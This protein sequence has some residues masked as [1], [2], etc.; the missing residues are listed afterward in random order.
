[1][2]PQYN[3][4][5]LFITS[6]GTGIGK[7]FLTSALTAYWRDSGSPVH[8]LKPVISGFSERDETSDT[9]QLLK[10]LGEPVTA[11]TI[12]AISPW[13]YREPLGP[14]MAA[15]AEGKTLPFD[16]L[17]S[18][19]QGALA[20]GDFTLIEG[21]GGAFVPLD[22]DHLVTDWITALGIPN[23]LVTTSTLGTLSHTIAT[24]RAM[25]EAQVSPLAVIVSEDPAS[26][27]SFHDTVAHMR[28]WLGDTK[29]LTLPYVRNAE[30]LAKAIAPLAHEVSA[31]VSAS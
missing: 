28:H 31:I 13:R 29:I 22:D 11:K 5:G 25:A 23:I 15:A 8:A 16:D 14:T 7:T 27:V 21:V 2:T 10:A 9:H 20:N 30:E 19:C 18:F 4:P 6:T 3:V 17:V 12:E 24:V 1:M 26:D